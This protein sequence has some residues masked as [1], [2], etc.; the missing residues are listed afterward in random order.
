MAMNPTPLYLV[1]TTGNLTEPLLGAGV[2]ASW[3][4]AADA[5][6]CRTPYGYRVCPGSVY[7]GWQ[8]P[9][10]TD[11]K[12]DLYAYGIGGEGGPDL[13]SISPMGPGNNSLP[14]NFGSLV[15]RVV[16]KYMIIKQTLHILLSR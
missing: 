12:K 16:S 9:L 2:I 13:A 7:A 15:V 5:G 8:A 1:A 3:P 11:C 4:M 14:K 6:L 10:P